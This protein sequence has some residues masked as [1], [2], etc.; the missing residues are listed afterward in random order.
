M[1]DSAT[2]ARLVQY[3]GTVQG[4]GFRFTAKSI[5]RHYPIAGWICNLADGSVEMLIEGS[6]AEVDACLQEIRSYWG[7]MITNESIEPCE[8]AGLSDFEIRR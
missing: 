6:A 3:R 1:A 4:V 8:P 7:A 5:A 2:I